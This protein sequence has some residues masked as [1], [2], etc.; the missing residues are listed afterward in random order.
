MRY[1]IYPP[2]NIEVYSVSPQFPQICRLD[3][4][5]VWKS[6]PHKM[7]FHVFS[8]DTCTYAPLTSVHST[9]KDCLFSNFMNADKLVK[10]K[11]FI[12]SEIST[13]TLTEY[14]VLITSYIANRSFTM[15]T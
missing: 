9:C 11:K 4:L 13:H 6:L 1:N 5:K 8:D 12:H 7:L 14:P 3:L 2:S 15:K 10:Y